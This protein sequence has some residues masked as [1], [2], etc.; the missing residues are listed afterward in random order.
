MGRM[1]TTLVDRKYKHVEL[2]AD[3]FEVLL[4]QDQRDTLRD[5]YE[6]DHNDEEVLARP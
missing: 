1:D 5:V 3:S 2:T 6:E 4:T